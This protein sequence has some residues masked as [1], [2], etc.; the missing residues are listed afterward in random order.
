MKDRAAER[1]ARLKEKLR[2]K[3]TERLEQ[4][5]PSGF[6]EPGRFFSQDA[7][8]VDLTQ[9]KNATATLPDTSEKVRDILPVLI[10]DVLECRRVY[11][12]TRDPTVRRVFCC[13]LRIMEARILDVQLCR[14]SV[15][16]DP[17][18][19]GYVRAAKVMAVQRTE[20]LAFVGKSVVRD[21]LLEPSDDSPDALRNVIL[22]EL[23][24]CNAAHELIDGQNRVPTVE[25]AQQWMAR[26]TSILRLLA[27]ALVVHRMFDVPV[28]CTSLDDFGAYC[29]ISTAIVLPSLR[30][31]HTLPYAP[32]F[33]DL[34]PLGRDLIS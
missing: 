14:G 27:P 18:F 5:D 24:L 22:Q 4:I 6:S 21:T 3:T 12:G 7:D 16:L 23:R 28:I 8:V 25:D 10:S 11:N 17:C 9:G 2:E 29:A 19:R 13:A 1:R 15:T 32:H 30:F 26:W 34:L 33:E 31:S 20:L